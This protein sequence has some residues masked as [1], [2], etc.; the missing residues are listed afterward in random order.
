MTVRGKTLLIIS[1]TCLGLVIVLYTAS[2][3]FLLG[4]F[5]KLEQASAR[6]NTQRVLNALDQDFGVMDRFTF[7][8]A[9]IDD[10]YNAMLNPSTESLEGILGKDASGTNQTRRF[11]FIV[12]IDTSGH[13][14][15]F[16]GLNLLTKQLMEIPQSLKS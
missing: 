1:I 8:R 15:A 5:I 16:R 2:R 3:S 14:I 10:T 13:A 4:G 7:D 12:L 9:S 11:N 6:E